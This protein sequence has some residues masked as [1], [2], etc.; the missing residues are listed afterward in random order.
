[1]RELSI[2]IKELTRRNRLGA[3]DA[4]AGRKG[5]FLSW[6]RGGSEREKGKSGVWAQAG[7]LR[8]G[9]SGA[10]HVS[11]ALIGGG[12]IQPRVAV[13]KDESVC[14][15]IR[16]TG[17]RPCRLMQADSRDRGELWGAV[18]DSE[19][20]NPGAGS[21]TITHQNENSFAH[22]ILGAIPNNVH[23][24]SKAVGERTRERNTEIP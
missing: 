22:C 9:A 20:P 11:T 12:N 21:E 15:W 5:H 19:L 13:R 4:V 6:R 1:M 10:R 2:R 18:T 8:S 14:A 7:A 17:R 16:D 3:E 23:C 24:E